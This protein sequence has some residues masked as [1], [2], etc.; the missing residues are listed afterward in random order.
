M[1]KTNILGVQWTY[2]NVVWVSG[3]PQRESVIYR[4][5]HI[6]F[7]MLFPYRPSP[8]IGCTLGLCDSIG[9]VYTSAYVPIP[10]S[11]CIPPLSVSPLVTLVWFRE[12]RVC[13]C[14]GKKTFCIIF[15]DSPHDWWC[16]VVLCLRCT[17]HSV[18][19]HLYH[20]HQIP[21]ASDIIWF[22]SFSEILHWV[23]SSPGSSMWL[24]MCLAGSFFWVRNIPLSK[25]LQEQSYVTT[26][27]EEF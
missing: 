9:C 3:V 26:G 14:L 5:V 11:Q 4:H 27:T 17:S 16:H 18:M 13:F 1:L 19:I 24:H 22:W 7:Q 21:H 23:W 8:C 12:H 6:C 10:T 2:Y 20:F 15:H 25:V